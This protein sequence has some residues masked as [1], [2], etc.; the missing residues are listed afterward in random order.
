MQSDGSTT[1]RLTTPP[2]ANTSPS[3]TKEGT[4][5]VFL[6]TRDA[7]NG[8]IYMMNADGSSIQRLTRDSTVKDSP[9]MAPEDDL[10]VYTVTTHEGSSLHTL[11]ISDKSTS[12]LIPASYAVASPRISPDGSFVLFAATAEGHSAVYSS[13][14][15]GKDLKRLTETSEDCR[16]PAWGRSKDE[17]VFSK[18]GGLF[19]LSLDAH[20][21]TQLTTGGDSFP[22]WID[23]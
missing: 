11:T 8:D 1:K 14:I 4:R 17:I 21:E 6:S 23:D 10:L 22:D 16:T 7:V 9:Q 12:T 15:D 2:G 19:L 5:I 20:R 3:W 18:F 13:T